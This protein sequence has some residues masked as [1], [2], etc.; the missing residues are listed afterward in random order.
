MN[1]INFLIHQD[2]VLKNSVKSHWLRKHCVLTNTTS[3]CG[4][5]GNGYVDFSFLLET[6]FLDFPFAFNS[7]T[8]VCFHCTKGSLLGKRFRLKRG[9]FPVKSQSWRAKLSRVD[10]FWQRGINIL[11][12]LP[13]LQ[14]YPFSWRKY[15]LEDWYMSTHANKRQ[16]EFYLGWWVGWGG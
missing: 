5:K 16:A 2:C 7:G 15:H 3:R 6:Q 12:K 10:S 13:S 8:S 11:A 1:G 14:G 9:D 4:I